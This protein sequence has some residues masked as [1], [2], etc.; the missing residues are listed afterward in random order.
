VS[1]HFVTAALAMSWEVLCYMATGIRRESFES[2]KLAREK[3]NASKWTCVLFGQEGDALEERKGLLDPLGLG[4]SK[5]Y[6]EHSHGG[7]A[8]ERGRW[9]IGEASVNGVRWGSFVGEKEARAKFSSSWWSK[10]LFDAEGAVAESWTAPLDVKGRGVSAIIKAYPI[11]LK[12]A[13]LDRRRQPVVIRSSRRS[14]N[15]SAV[16]SFLLEPEAAEAIQAGIEA[17]L[18]AAMRK[19]LGHSLRQTCS[20]LE[21][22][23]PEETGMEGA[24]FRSRSSLSE[25][26]DGREA[27]AHIELPRSVEARPVTQRFRGEPQRTAVE[28]GYSPLPSPQPTT[29][30]TPSSPTIA[31]AKERHSPEKSVEFVLDSFDD[32]SSRWARKLA[33]VGIISFDR[34]ELRFIDAK[35]RKLAGWPQ[36]NDKFPIKVQYR[37]AEASRAQSARRPG[38]PRCSGRVEP[39]HG[40]L[41][42]NLYASQGLDY[43][44]VQSKAQN[45][46]KAI[47]L[48]VHD[49]GARNRNESGRIIHNQC[50]YL[51][52]ARGWLGHNASKDHIFELALRL[53]RAIEAA[54]IAERPSWRQEVGEEALAFADFLPIAMKAG[55]G[56]SAVRNFLAELAVC[57]FDAAAGY[58]EVY[59]GPTYASLDK[60]KRSRR[61]VLLW[62]TP[63]HYQ[64]L[65]HNDQRG[66]KVVMTYEEFKERLESQGVECI[67]TYGG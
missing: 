30:P 45:F 16:G 37:H 19:Q 13:L 22:E 56:E 46:L 21:G 49:A 2:E 11:D 26:V 55:Q 33:S 20:D 64:C 29:S 31:D 44:V 36:E 9:V 23:F 62:F 50:F 61:L 60:G 65:V 32:F 1:F 24:S 43:A 27:D 7:A 41:I 3:F 67:E 8:P 39:D 63:G 66:S 6:E 18:E 28:P 17:E 51:S 57:I 35:G 53:K 38:S 34:E 4:I 14:S 25:F 10:V 12:A 42:K 47:G 40:Q 52:L 48:R 59:L 54:V 15:A 5:I 58:V